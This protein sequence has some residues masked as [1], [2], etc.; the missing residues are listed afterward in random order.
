MKIIVDLP[1][2]WCEEYHSELKKS[3]YLNETEFEVE[4]RHFLLRHC[5]SLNNSDD[6]EELKNMA[7]YFYF[8]G[9]K[10]AQEGMICWLRELT[11]QCGDS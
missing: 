6:A 11:K 8:S 1:D 3:K 10:A 4:N 5:F 9:M 7:R 2:E